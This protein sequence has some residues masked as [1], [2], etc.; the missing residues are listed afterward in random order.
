[1]RSAVKITGLATTAL[2]AMVIAAPAAAAEASAQ[3]QAGAQQEVPAGADAAK[4][5]DAGNE[6]VVTGLRGRPRTVTDSPVPVD[7]FTADA[8]EKSGGQ[9]DTLNTLQT[10]VPSYSVPRSANTTSDSFIRAPRLR[11]LPADQTLLLVNG[12]RRHK[13]ASVQVS[14]AGS[15]SADAAVIPG[16]ALKSV[17]VLRDG[18][19]AQYGSDA[20]A[21][22]INFDLKDADHGGALIIQGGQYYRGD[23]ESIQIAGNIGLPL[24]DHGFINISGEWNNDAATVRA[25]RFTSTAWDPITAYNTDAAFREAVDAAHLDLNEPL[26]K[27]GK[28]KERA[29]RFVVNSGLDIDSESQIYAFGN[30]SKSKGTAAATYRTPGGGHAVMDNP[31]RLQDGTIWR[32]RDEYPLGLQPYFSGEVTDYSGTFGW[33]TKHDWDNGQSLKVDVSGRYGYDK[34]L[35]SITDSVNPSMG[36][37]SPSYFRASYYTNDETAV[38]ADFEYSIPVGVLAGPLVFNFGSEWRRERFGIGAGEPNSYGIGTWGYPDPFDFCTNEVNYADRTLTANAPAGA[39]I[40]CTNAKD[41]VYNVLQ[42]G[43]NGIT[44]LPPEVAKRYSTDAKSFYGEI[45]T[46]IT[47]QWFVDFAARY[48][49]YESFGDKAVWKVATRYSVTDWLGLRGSIGTGFRAPTAGQINMTQTQIQTTGGIPLNT[50]LYPA[51]SPVS[52]YLGAKPL[53]PE[54]SKNYSL[55]VT[56]KPLAGL[57]LTV[58]AYKVKVSDQIYATTLITVTPEIEQ[59]MIAAGIVGAS[60]IN[61]VNFFQNA[62][63]STVNGFD[64]VAAYQAR[65]IGSKPLNVTAAF[66]WNE[67]NIDKVNISQVTFNDVSI[68]NFENNNPKLRG[69]VTLFQ[70]FGPVS[71]MARGNFYGAY[72]RQTTA[73]GNAK[74]RYGPEVFFDLEVTAPLAER[75][76]LTVGARNLFDKYPPINRI[77]D[78]NGRLYYDG[79]VDWQG[80][81]YYARLSFNF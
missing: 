21:G 10:L 55:G 63:D 7:V 56:L 47:K 70:D 75:Y 5:D 42:P 39:G 13:S 58:D 17:E 78:T 20:I 77:D 31:V 4:S 41:P 40:V 32:F 27:R 24:T 48:E 29:I 57:T 18:A 53:G 45:T 11:G 64:V 44:G 30:F 12:R 35:Y 8:I 46:D 72:S 50:G 22:V 62:F 28:P 69:N 67:Y 79:V 74:Q 25:G 19:A 49:D 68:Y 16:I 60:S 37:D 1:M 71:V 54:T 52:Q 51:T 2:Y 33:R 36:P 43:S 80:G 26:E 38:N 81:Y 15:Q 9:T 61:Q 6:I 73:A 3:Q 34:I 76:S 65:V 59:A 66:N 14:G 23:G